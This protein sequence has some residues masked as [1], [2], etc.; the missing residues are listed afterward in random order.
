MHK[1]VAIFKVIQKRTTNL[2]KQQPAATAHKQ[3]ND[4]LMTA[5]CVFVYERDD[6]CVRGNRAWLHLGSVYFHLKNGQWCICVN[7]MR[8]TDLS[9]GFHSTE[10]KAKD[11]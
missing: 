8:P 7:Y 1:H 2:L 4:H 5:P 9:R 10:E 3:F 6:E 11:F